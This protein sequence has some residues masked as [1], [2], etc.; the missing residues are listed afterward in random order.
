GCSAW[1][2]DCCSR[3][4]SPTAAVEWSGSRCS[5][6]ASRR[7]RHWRPSC[8]GAREPGARAALGSGA[9]AKAPPVVLTAADREVTITNPE[10]VYFPRAG[11]TKLDLARYYAAVAP[12]ALRGIAGRPIVLKRYVDGAE[13]EPFF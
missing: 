1:V 3:T 5:A 7:R 11:Y 13:G 4:A 9:M 10:K 2:P 6:S 8:C 12:G